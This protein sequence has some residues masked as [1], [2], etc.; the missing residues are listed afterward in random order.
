MKTPHPFP[1]AG[2]ALVLTFGLQP[3]APVYGAT[4]ITTTNRCAY[5]AN[6]GWVDA[7]GDTNN[8]AVIGEYVCSGYMYA[9]NVGWI[10]LGSGSPANGI[11]YQNN[12]ATDF[13]VNLSLSEL[14]VLRGF[15][16]G[17]NIGWV[18]FESTGV[19][20]VNMVSG[21]FSGYAW[22]ANCGW[23]SLSNAWAVVQTG[24]IAAGTDS[25][26][27]GIADTWERLQFGNLTTA[28]A[29]SDY[30][31]DSMT[32]RQ[33]YLAATLPK[34]ANDRFLITSF[35]HSASSDL[36]Y[37][38]WKSKSTR[39]YRIE[40]RSALDSAAPW[41]PYSMGAPDNIFGHSAWGLYD[42]DPQR[43]YRVR[44]VRPLTP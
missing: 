1:T 43:L 7:C 32:D 29:T 24:S 27:D 34:D 39:C 19:P 23:I 15:A 38:N 11:Q 8:G 41:E 44:V 31:G 40:R 42:Y 21:Q 18:N 14:G 13:G 36:T 30:D 9:A 2:L 20:K 6:V 26:G 22:S 12:S 16:W 10:N 37:L 28:N 5:G 17:A 25:D 4:T 35:A 3:L 33:E